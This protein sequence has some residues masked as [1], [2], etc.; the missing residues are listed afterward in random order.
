MVKHKETSK[1]SKRYRYS[2]FKNRIDNIRIEPAKNL[3]KRVHDHV[4][5]SHFLA[6][7]EHWEDTNL[8]ATFINFADA[9]RPLSSTLPQIL[10]NESEIFNYIFDT[11]SKHDEN[12]LQPMLDLLAQFCHDLGPDFMKFYTRCMQMLTHLLDDA[13]NFESSDVFEWGFNCL[14]Y[15]YKY[16]SRILAQDLLLTYDLLFPL[17][18]HDKEYLSR[19]SAEVLSF[20]VRK[21][22]QTSLDAFINHTFAQLRDD[23]TEHL[24]DGL[25]ILFTETLVSTKESLHSKFGIIMQ[26]LIQATLTSAENSRCVSV[27][28]DVIMNVLRHASRENAKQ[29]Y[30]VTLGQIE[31]SLKSGAENTEVATKLLIPLAYAESGQKVGSWSNL[32]C[33]IQRLIAHAGKKLSP[34]DTSLLFCCVLRNSPIPDLTQCYKEFFSF[35]MKNFGANFTEFF[36]LALSYDRDRVLSFG[37]AKYLQKFF[38]SEWP[39]HSKKMAFFLLEIESNVALVEKLGVKVSK[40]LG[41][42]QLSAIESMD[43]NDEDMIFD[44]YW[45]LL[46]VSYCDCDNS[47]VLVSTLDFFLRDGPRNDFEKDV[48]GRILSTITVKETS[49]FKQLLNLALRRIET[50]QDSKLCVQG[51]TRIINET[52]AA[53]YGIK[54]NFAPQILVSV[55]QNLS[56]PDD[57][58]RYESLNLILAIIEFEGIQVPHFLNECRLIE[59]IPRNLQNARDIT[60]R[61][62]M[63]G[64]AFAKTE[65]ENFACHALFNYLFGI[66][67]VRFSPV[68]EGVYEI[69]PQIFEKDQK[70]T[71]DLFLKF[72]DALDNNFELDYYVPKTAIAEA[73]GGWSVSVSRLN[74]ALQSC[75]KVFTS[76]ASIDRS[77]I[78]ISKEK[79]SDL[80]YPG[81]IRNQ[82]LK[83]L[84]SIPQ[85]AERHSKDI[86]PYF[87]KAS[88]VDSELSGADASE[89]NE[90]RS[91]NTWSETDRK[92]L[93]KLIGKFKNIKAIYRSEDVHRRLMDLLG[94]R[95]TEIQKLA[96]DGILAYRDKGVIKYR[97]NLRNLLDDNAFKD[98]CLKLLAR[99]DEQIIEPQDETTIMPVILRI[100]FGRAQTPVTSGLK[101]SRKAA[102]VTLLPSLNE[103]YVVDFLT[104]A[105]HGTH[106]NEN[107]SLSPTIASSSMR[108]MVG[109]V[110]LARAAVSA[111]G[112]RYPYATEM[113]IHPILLTL[114][115]SNEVTLGITDQDFILK[116]AS[117][118]RQLSIKLMHSI[119]N[120]VGDRIQWGVYVE[121]IF[122]VM[123]KP[124]L[125]RFEDEN[126]QQPSSLMAIISFWASDVRYYKF[127][128]YDGCSAAHALMRTL[129]KETAKDSVISSILMFSNSI[130]KNPTEES[131]YIDLVTLVASACLQS[132]PSLLNLDKNQDINAVSADLL[133]NLV[134]AGYVRENEVKK[135]I[136]NSLALILEGEL[137]AFRATDKLKILKTIAALLTDYE[138]SWQDIEPLYK[139]CSKLYRTIAEKEQRQAI[140]EIFLS[141]GKNF[142]HLKG[143]C[144]L[145]NDLNGYST[146]RMEAYNFDTVLPA[147]KKINEEGYLCLSDTEW[148]PIINTCLFYIQDEEELAIRTNASHSLKRY[149]D[150]INSKATVE[151]ARC[152]VGTMT[153]D[154]M[155]Q[156]KHGLRHKNIDIQA[157]FISVIAYIVSNSRYYTELQDM[158]VLQFNADEEAN[159]FANI[160]HI[161]LHRRQRAIKRLS[162][163]ASALSGNSISHFLIP[164]IERYIYCTDEKYRNMCNEAILAIGNLTN[165]VTWNQYKALIRR[166]ASLMDSKPQYL[167]EIILLI[168]KCSSA[169]ADSMCAVRLQTVHGPTM[170]KFPMTLSDQDTFV[171]E[172]ICPR[173]SK[174]LNIRNDETIVARMPLCE[175]MVNFTM[176]LDT[177]DRASLLPGILSSIC[178]VLRSRSEELREAVRKTLANITIRLGPRYFTFILKELKGAL[179]RGSQ[180]HV[181]SYT[182][183]SLLMALLPTMVHKDLDCTAQ[184]IVGVL[185]EDIFGTAGQEKDAEG[186]NSKLKELKYNKSYDT[187]EILAA[188]ISLSVFGSLLSPVNALLSE[189][190]GLKTQR[191]LN[192]LLRR[193]ALGLNHNIESSSIDVLTLCYEIYTQTAEYGEVKQKNRSYRPGAM[194]DSFFVVNLNAKTE[195]VQTEGR[196]NSAILQKFSL[197]LLRT[198]L[199]RNSNLLEVAYLSNFVPLLRDALD[200]QDEGVLISALRVLIVLVKLQFTEENE[201]IFK[202]CARKVLNVIHD[203][204][205]TSSELCQV[206]LKYLSSLIRHKN[207]ELKD[208]ALSFILGRIKPDLNE[209]NKQGLA[210]NF[211]K[212]LLYKHIVLPELYDIVDAI[213]EIMVTNHSREIRDV[214]RSVYY[215]FLME[216]D[217]SRGRLEKQFSF[218]VSNLEYPSQDGRQSVMEL[219]NLIVNKSNPELLARLFSSFFLSLSNVA[220]NDSSPRCREMGS[221]LL[222]A[223]LM[224]VGE[225]GTGPAEKYISA[226]LKHENPVFVELGL[227]I[228]KIF[229]AAVSM[230]MNKTL[231]HLAISRAKGIISECSVGSNTEWN[232]LYTALNL[233]SN[234]V[235]VVPSCFDNDN[236]AMWA[237]VEDCLLYPHLWVRLISAR[238]IMKYLAKR[239]ELQ[240][241]LPDYEL[242]T[243]AYRIFRQL[244]APSVSEALASTA[245]RILAT[246]MKKWIENKSPFISNSEESV[247]YV[248]AMDFALARIGSILRDE[249]NFQE[250]F[251]SKKACVQ[252]FALIVQMMNQSLVKDVAPKIILPLF[253]YLEDE[254]KVVDDQV[255]ELRQLSQE[256]LELLQS[257]LSVTEFS[258][259]YSTV[260][261]EIIQRRYERRAKRATL[262]VT[263]P[264]AAARRK[265]KKHARSKEKRKHEKDDN[266]FYRAKNKKRKF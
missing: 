13:V 244:G 221:A 108:R 6:S 217:Q 7:F 260:K 124:R 194:E 193:Y 227:K 228:Y 21:A 163:N 111:L 209:P 188:N 16:L 134:D 31:N 125:T 226:W 104:L 236:S 32:I 170:E 198:A 64:S 22:K 48:M 259:A 119:F 197:D 205:S 52:V 40:E 186:Y 174:I 257:K 59:E 175:S 262:A 60:M 187:G 3:A 204:P 69:L 251:N 234:Y 246:V 138:C 120:T 173:F 130:I 248:T 133:L 47:R 192:E 77:I 97:D 223:L 88:P 70:L 36:K 92:L 171:K 103:K 76:Y 136:L 37:G 4:E 9:V 247:K 230:G 153:S 80:T 253:T 229:A 85:L 131:N 233:L 210:F 222:K 55:T 261:Q 218:L 123:V 84:Q 81:L 90:Y 41:L 105:S 154:L 20:L 179:R 113:L 15:I 147:F 116:Q 66:L 161:Q 98:E 264:E 139:S 252:L 258:S 178:Q 14:A 23:N 168:A 8:S 183:H 121:K 99:S 185:M 142:Q 235:D 164:M 212:S 263:A 12:A 167:K 54:Y 44:L 249:E 110:T 89:D 200:S 96:F 58:I 215:Q 35:Y 213:A 137:K 62:R 242:Q 78:E 132:L 182:I 38:N 143:A 91:S 219:I 150:Y 102:V 24:Y 166:F 122:E 73:Q 241:P 149:V 43:L 177:M 95:T 224:K 266:G 126:L 256:C 156:L 19:F 118:L 208:T 237:H 74:D 201:G 196:S 39:L 180:I 146:N 239:E 5:T 255:Q 176:G 145:L 231:G 11:I 46:L 129:S 68:W 49:E 33:C 245:V 83:G 157:E 220:A 160:T 57:S 238:M 152:S 140:N 107:L 115:A 72:I 30:D 100:L 101:R 106:T 216:Y 17:L 51:L 206:S 10:F 165:Y 2:S 148:F 27:I 25:R 45:R 184:L 34:S 18:S 1:S 155:P 189:N 243:I 135:H 50:I 250:T 158:K 56:L 127:L 109:F 214:S 207:I 128:Y 190:L 232:L 75:R 117:T 61:L 94:S 199:S 87:L 63:I 28:A 202:G 141:I 114:S 144:T 26:T 203:S 79:R 65:P 93:L 172:E 169:L 29:L 53:G 151:E 181:L 265:L 82:A 71:W 67:T 191:K 42:E 159:F 254:R 211:V 240:R 86:V 162:E 225:D 195:K 112:S